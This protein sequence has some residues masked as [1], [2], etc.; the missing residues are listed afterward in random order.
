M[1]ETW[2]YPSWK[3]CRANLKA[4]YWKEKTSTD[5]PEKESVEKTERERARQKELWACQIKGECLGN[6]LQTKRV[7][8]P[9]YEPGGK[10]AI[11]R[12]GNGV[13]WVQWPLNPWETSGEG[14][15]GRE[16]NWWGVSGAGRPADCVP[17]HT[18]WHPH[19][20]VDIMRTLH[21]RELE[22]KRKNKVV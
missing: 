8:A 13:Q 19:R 3:Y 11:M 4:Y 7:R 17:A 18:G 15:L 12:M 10:M 9:L 6:G 5:Y 1:K 21:Q 20:H 14:V 22:R 16:G 2:I